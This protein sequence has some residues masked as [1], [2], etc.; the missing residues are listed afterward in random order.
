MYTNIKFYKHNLFSYYEKKI[1]DSFLF[2]KSNYKS[3]RISDSVYDVLNMSLT[4][5]IVRNQIFIAEFAE[6]YKSKVLVCA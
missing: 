5:P 6:L 4:E 1:K 2:K 3:Y